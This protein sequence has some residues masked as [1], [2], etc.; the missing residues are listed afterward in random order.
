MS[1]LQLLCNVFVPRDCEFP[2]DDEDPYWVALDALGD[3]VAASVRT[4]GLDPDELEAMRESD[5]GS[6]LTISS[7]APKWA[8]RFWVYLPRDAAVQA[9]LLPVLL[10]HL[11]DARTALDDADWDVTLGERPLVWDSRRFVILN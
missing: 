9:A 8:M 10:G 1:S 11:A 3:A 6:L 5:D 7:D 4:R 2:Q